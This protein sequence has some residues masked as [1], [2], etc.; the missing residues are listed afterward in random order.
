MRTV[1]TQVE[2]TWVHNVILVY[3]VLE[4]LVLFLKFS[5]CLDHGLSIWSYSSPQ[6][7][8]PSPAYLNKV[9]IPLFEFVYDFTSYRIPLIWIR[10]SH[11]TKI[12]SSSAYNIDELIKSTSIYIN[13]PDQVVRLSVNVLNCSVIERFTSL[14]AAKPVYEVEQILLYRWIS[15]IIPGNTRFKDFPRIQSLFVKVK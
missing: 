11:W 15:I 3:N 4:H 8:L 12:K 13:V 1:L 5:R 7:H 2:L 9:D 14:Y 6:F 10:S